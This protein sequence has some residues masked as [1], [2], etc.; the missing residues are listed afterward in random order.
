M[1]FFSTFFNIFSVFFS[2]SQKDMKKCMKKHS[3]NR[4]FS[5]FFYH[6]FRRILAFGLRRRGILK[7]PLHPPFLASFLVETDGVP[8]SI[9]IPLPYFLYSSLIYFLKNVV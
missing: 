6:F 9:N 8:G 7:L 1:P 2:T 5:E 4:D 3:K